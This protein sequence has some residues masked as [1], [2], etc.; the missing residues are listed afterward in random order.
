MEKWTVADIPSQTGNLAVVT[1]ANSGIGRHTALELARAGSE[2]ILA[3][4]T[5]AKGRET[6]E[7]IRRQLPQAN[8][9]AEVLDLASLQSVRA[10]AAKV[11]G[12]T[13]LDLLVRISR[14]ISNARQILPLAK[15]RAGIAQKRKTSDDKSQTLCVWD[16]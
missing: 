16:C 13:K 10:F 9:R 2:V 1:G 5:E 4:R 8:V 6:V 15:S 7:L 11:R 3:V 14:S 12:E